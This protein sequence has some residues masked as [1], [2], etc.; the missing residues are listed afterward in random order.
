MHFRGIDCVFWSIESTPHIH[1]QVLS[2][3]GFHGKKNN[4]LHL[5]FKSDLNLPLEL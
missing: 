5:R 2:S 1:D 3:K 4:C